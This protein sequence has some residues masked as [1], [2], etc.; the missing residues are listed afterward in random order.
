M[1][2]HTDGTTAIASSTFTVDYYGLY[3]GSGSQDNGGS[4]WIGNK[5][6]W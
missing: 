2:A 6:D 5:E 1:S 4:V 3:I